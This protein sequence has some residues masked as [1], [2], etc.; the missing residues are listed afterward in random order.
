MLNWIKRNGAWLALALIAAALCR[1]EATELRIALLAALFEALAIAV[2]GVAL[3]AYT[4][5]DFLR[6]DWREVT[7]HVFLGVH[8]CLGLVAMGIFFA[9]PAW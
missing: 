6:A 2:S 8:I 4:K 1:P 9:Q 7:A 3:Y 5:I